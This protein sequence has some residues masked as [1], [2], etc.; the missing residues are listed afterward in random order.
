MDIKKTLLAQAMKLAQNPKVMEIAMNPK[1]ME[2]AMKAMAAKAEVTTAMH[3]ATNSVA[4][5]LN[6]ATRDEVKELRR[7]IRKLEDQL[8]ASRTE[9]GEKP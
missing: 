4:R 1:V 8:A 7:T 9:A 6:L 3:G 5:G 2:V